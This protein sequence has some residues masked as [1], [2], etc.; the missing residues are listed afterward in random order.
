MLINKNLAL[1]RSE[2]GGNGGLEFLYRIDQYGISA[3]SHPREELSEIHWEVDIV[4][5]LDSKTFRYEI[6][7]ETELAD[8]TLVFHNDKSLNEFLEKAF[9]SLSEIKTLESMFEK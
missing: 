8:K 2:P 4:K 6:C 3:I 7:T 5:F 9:V 1:T